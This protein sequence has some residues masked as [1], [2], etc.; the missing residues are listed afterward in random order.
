MYG[1]FWTWM[2]FVHQIL[3]SREAVVVFKS[4]FPYENICLVLRGF[5]GTAAEGVVSL[6][7]ATLGCVFRFWD[8][9]SDGIRSIDYTYFWGW[10]FCWMYFPKNRTFISLSNGKHLSR[11]PEKSNQINQMQGRAK[12]QTDI[13]TPPCGPSKQ[14]SMIHGCFRK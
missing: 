3:S 11:N 13:K 1:K 2:G 9:S 10:M 7:F 8:D 5:E 4:G 12:K 14:I 6:T